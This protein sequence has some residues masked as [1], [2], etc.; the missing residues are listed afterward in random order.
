[1]KSTTSYTSGFRRRSA[2]LS[3]SNYSGWSRIYFS[4]ERRKSSF[5]SSKEVP[6]PISC[7]IKECNMFDTELI[8]DST[9]GFDM[10][11]A[12]FT[13]DVEFAFMSFIASARF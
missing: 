4:S 9:E 12:I 10:L 13:W 8:T 5:P 6:C 1:M 2:S 7:I 11:V 3:S